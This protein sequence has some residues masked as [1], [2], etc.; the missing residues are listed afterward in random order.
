VVNKAGPSIATTLSAETI[1]VGGTVHDSATITGATTNAG[2]TVTYTV[3]TNDTCD[4]SDPI[5]AGTKTVT[6]GVV[7]DSGGPG[8]FRGGAPS[9]RSRRPDY[10]PGTN[11][12]TMS[13][14][15]VL[16]ATGVAERTGGAAR[17]GAVNL[18]A[19]SRASG[20]L[21]TTA[22]R[23]RTAASRGPSPPRSGR[24]RAR[25]RGEARRGGGR[26]RPRART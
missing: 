14:W 18:S 25:A 8:K 4:S 23:A 13:V 22:G 15:N 3:Y 11:L 17:T 26:P 16:E 24:L 1:P 19:S 9:R 20:A 12:P 6:N 21:A 2:G 5:D 7:P 10:T